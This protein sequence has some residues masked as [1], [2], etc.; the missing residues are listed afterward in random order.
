MRQRL[1][2][3][4]LGPNIAPFVN[5]FRPAGTTGY[6]NRQWRS[7]F[8]S[9]P[10]IPTTGLLLSGGVDS[11]VLLDQLLSRGWRVVPFYVRTDCV[12]QGCELA[13][14][15][16]F[17]CAV[18]KPELQELVVFDMPLADLYRDHWSMTGDNVPDDA[19]PDEAVFL[20]GRNPLLLI[21]P[22]LWC[23]M[24]GVENLAMATL[25]NNPF[26]DAAP[27]FFARFEEMIHVAAGVTVRIA[28]PFERLSKRRVMEL[29]HHLPLALTFSCLSPVDG[30]HCGR[31]NKCAERRLAFSQ[32]G[33]DDGTE[34]AIVKSGKVDCTSSR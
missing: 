12:W 11:A 31:C 33:I 9:P 16:Q 18:T 2:Y 34:Y 29:G 4:T 6:P 15:K 27:E 23:A 24:H 13:A 26:D 22:V 1:Q 20:P 21:K 28:R 25:S 30:L 19:T 17:L 14:V 3:F 32:A 7:I 8:M 5:R 10:V